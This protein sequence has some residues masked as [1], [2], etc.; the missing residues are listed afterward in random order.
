M[1][2]KAVV[3]TALIS[4]LGAG[5][6]AMAQ[7]PGG[8]GPGGGFTPPTFAD[9]DKDK[10]GKITKEEIAAYN[11]ARAAAAPGG[12]GG[13]PPQNPDE[14]LGRWDTNKDGTV[15]QAEFDARPR[16]Q[17]GPGGGG[18]GGGGA[19]GPPRP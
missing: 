15:S 3:L 4:V 17:G 19:G 16:G 10:N 7:P 1:L 14:V 5:H 11:A 8:G 13:R 2:K 9:Y 18:G 6:F 12:G